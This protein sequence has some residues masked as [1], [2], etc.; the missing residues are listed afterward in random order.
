MATL[1]IREYKEQTIDGDG[2]VLPAGY[3]DGNCTG[4]TVSYTTS[5]Q[6]SAFATNTT[7]I[8]VVADASA[9]L[10]FGSNPTATTGDGVYLPADTV[11]YFRVNSGD[12]VAAYDG[13][14]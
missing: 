1:Y 11:E 12:K 9:Y 13:T 4:Q 10:D 14:S 5:T 3:E 2:H 7:F 6:S 8:R